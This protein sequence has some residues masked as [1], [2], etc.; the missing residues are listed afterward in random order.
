MD[1]I[2]KQCFDLF[3]APDFSNARSPDPSPLNSPVKDARD[4]EDDDDAPPTIHL[5]DLFANCVG[6]SPQRPT[7][8]TPANH[9]QKA[10]PAQEPL[11][12]PQPRRKVKGP[13]H[14]SFI[15]VARRPRNLPP[16]RR[17]QQLQE[18]RDTLHERQV[19]AHERRAAKSRDKIR[20][21]VR[22][23]ETL[24]KPK[25]MTKEDRIFMKQLANLGLEQQLNHDLERFREQM[26]RAGAQTE[27]R[28]KEHEA[29]DR[30]AEKLCREKTD[31]EAL[32]EQR[33]KVEEFAR[34]SE[35][36]MLKKALRAEQERQ[37]AHDEAERNLREE[38]E[39]RLRED[40]ARKAKQEEERRRQEEEERRRREDK[41]RQEQEEWRRR[42]QELHDSIERSRRILM[43]RGRHAEEA[44]RLEEEASRQRQAARERRLHEEM[45]RR[46][47]ETEERRQAHLRAEQA[48]RVAEEEQIRQYFI[49]YESKWNELRTNNSLPPID[50]RE[51]PWP[52]FG[53]I[54][55]ADQI[56]YQDV[57]AFLLYPQRPG[58]EGKT[59][60][61][62]VKAEVLRFH[63]DKFNT[64]IVPRI[65]PSQQAV[66]QEIAGAIARI[67]TTI[68]TEVE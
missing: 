33:K 28:R 13:R 24:M 17:S 4:S 61:D 27:Q 6:E 25:H 36:G 57:R 2:P 26:A 31:E 1:Y 63:P 64:R 10:Q 34:R 41:L 43:E 11:P 19:D 56:T 47:R 38:Q 18:K 35:E 3:Q 12:I 55:S 23:A 65:L 22:E 62:K 8:P 40:L 66:A 50:V 5:A 37:R 46:A 48:R 54:S 9:R 60:R 44:R 52:V 51:M 30:E 67:L 49:V 59:A 39:R 15:N 16:H 45:E 14:L 58:V 68:M 53:V 20:A 32:E 7:T 42:I 29:R 21:L